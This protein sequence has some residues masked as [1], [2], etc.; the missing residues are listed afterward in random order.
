VPTVSFTKNLQRHIECPDRD[1]EAETVREALEAVFADTPRL[2]GYVLDDN[3]AVRRHVDIFVDGHG[4]GDRHAQSDAVTAD[5]SRGP[6]SRLVGIARI[7]RVSRSGRG[8]RS[9]PD[10]G[11]TR[12][13]SSEPSHTVATDTARN[14]ARRR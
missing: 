5:S 12:T 14:H 3:G 8:T 1:V 6:R 7:R 2:R 13:S 9:E 10:S 11:V 4:I